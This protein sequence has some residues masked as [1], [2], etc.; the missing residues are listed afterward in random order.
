MRSSLFLILSLAVHALCVTAV[1][2]APQRVSEPSGKEIE[3][4]VGE[5]AEQ[6]GLDT[7]RSEEPSTAAAA[8]AAVPA[9]PAPKSL[10]PIKPAAAAP[11]AQPAKRSAP[12]AKASIKKAAVPVAAT[13]ETPTVEDEK[14]APV[15]EMTPEISE[16]EGSK[17]DLAAATNSSDANEKEET[18]KFV[19]I[20]ESAPAGIEADTSTEA[21][22]RD[23]EKTE[24]PTPAIAG[25]VGDGELNKGGATA[26]GAVNYLELKQLPGNKPPL[27]PLMAR[28]ELRQGQ[29]EL[30]Y[31]VTKE[32]T[33]A[34]V[35]IAKSSGSKDLD[36]EAVKAISKFRFVA[37]QEG[38]ARHP[39]A[40]NLKGVA[41]TLPGKLRSAK[42]E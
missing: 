18:P 29:V 33:V 4:A 38:W 8:A 5:P 16:E 17:A 14:A 28:K 1:V 25:T 37:G 9:A 12:V 34:D 30:V 22:S 7:A 35:E 41:Q 10:E 32:G 21:T 15:E 42:S 27:Y 26:A 31:R 3:V 13:T 6:P 20:K 19:P 40:F 36:S 2:L 23:V 24:D 39:V 11:K